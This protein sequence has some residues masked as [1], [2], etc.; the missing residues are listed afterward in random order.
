ML[1]YALYT[2]VEVTP[3]NREKVYAFASV[4]RYVHCLRQCNQLSPITQKEAVQFSSLASLYVGEKGDEKGFA[5]DF[6][7]IATN[8]IC[9][10][11]DG[12]FI[13]V[14]LVENIADERYYQNSTYA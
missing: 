1:L 10:R 13:E 9:D 7:D 3:W 14:Q 6:I 5:P 12:K 4:E 11:W 2:P 8:A